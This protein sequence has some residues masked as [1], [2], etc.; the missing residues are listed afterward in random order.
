MYDNDE[1]IINVED[2]C[3]KYRN[4]CTI[5]NIKNIYHYTSPDGLESIINDKSILFS[6]YR[7]LNDEKELN[8]FIDVIK[9]ILDKN[10]EKNSDFYN[11]M[12]NDILKKFPKDITTFFINDE[13]ATESREQC[14]YYI[15]STSL[16]PD[17]LSMWNYYS[18]VANADGYNIKINLKNFL[19]CITQKVIGSLEGLKVNNNDSNAIYLGKVIYNKK[20]QEEYANQIIK[21]YHDQYQSSSEKSDDNIN[22]LNTFVLIYSFFNKHPS[23]IAEDEF[24]IIIAYP[25]SIK[26]I[27]DKKDDKKVDLCF[28][29]TNGSFAP[30]LKIKVDDWKDIIKEVKIGPKNKMDIAESGLRAFLDYNG[31]DEKNVPVSTSDI[32]VRF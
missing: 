13:T 25:N 26:L 20:K 16:K 3:S 30:K 19:D 14:N 28:Q 15:L 5:Q 12:E 27:N 21:L 1:L 11:H 31:L 22:V 17:I 4:N 24:R 8:Y 6:D 18:K 10:Y 7:F 32:P 9:E 23:F 29:K 2:V